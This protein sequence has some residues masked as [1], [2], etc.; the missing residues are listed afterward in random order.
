MDWK[1]IK[2]YIKTGIIAFLTTLL[3]LMGFKML[4]MQREVDASRS[5][6]LSAKMELTSVYA[7]K[8]DMKINLMQTI[9][10]KEDWINMQQRHID[11]LTEEVEASQ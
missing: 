6:E 5:A 10:A 9:A 1:E 3:V 11:Q 7:D 8:L 4:G 2:P